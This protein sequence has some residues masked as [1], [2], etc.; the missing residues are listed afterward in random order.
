MRGDV[1]IV[2]VNNET[3]PVH[4]D[5]IRV[6]E[7]DSEVPVEVKENIK[8]EKPVTAPLKPKKK[9]APVKAFKNIKPTNQGSIF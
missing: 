9:T 8:H 4:R 6:Q 3:F 5:C 2:E 1:W 7:D